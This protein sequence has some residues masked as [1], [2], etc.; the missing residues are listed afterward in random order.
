MEAPSTGAIVGTLAVI[1]VAIAIAIAAGSNLDIAVPAGVAAV[2]FASALGL[3]GTLAT[4]REDPRP[5][6]FPDSRPSLRI[7][8]AFAGDRIHREEVVLLL[9]HVERA[10]PNPALPS[11]PRSE[12]AAIVSMDP[13]GFRG[14]VAS[15]IELLERES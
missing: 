1:G 15:R 2:A 11:R 8:R 7:L 14:Y 6:R 13:A 10:G 5:L 3:S 4:S 9:D 12:L